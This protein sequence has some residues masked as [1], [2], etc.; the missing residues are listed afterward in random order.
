MTS[1]TATRRTTARSPRK[2]SA[3]RPAGPGRARSWSV[4]RITTAVRTAP[5]ARRCMSLVLA[6]GSLIAVERGDREVLALLQR[7]RQQ[8]RAPL[9]HGGVLGQSMC[10]A[11]CGAVVRDVRRNSRAWLTALV[12]PSAPARSSR[13][14]QGA[15]PCELREDL[16]RGRGGGARDGPEAAARAA[17][18]PPSTRPP[19]GKAFP[20]A[21]RWVGSHILD[22]E[23]SPRSTGNEVDVTA[24]RGHH[25]VAPL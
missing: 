4:G 14:S 11:R 24:V 25:P 19:S 20:D 21:S 7:E 12:L 22:M 18:T 16:G 9:T 10:S 3:R 8:G 6:A 2:R 23:L 13:S 17:A 15:D 1:W 5:E